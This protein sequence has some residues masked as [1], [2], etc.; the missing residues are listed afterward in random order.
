LS[1]EIKALIEQYE[2]SEAD[3][4]TAVTLQIMTSREYKGTVQDIV[5]G[6]VRHQVTAHTREHTRRVEDRAFAHGDPFME[7]VGEL[8]LANP[9]AARQELLREKF[10]CP[11]CTMY[12]TWGEATVDC[13][14]GR[15]KYMLAL[16]NTVLQDADR[17]QAA[18]DKLRQYGVK[19]LNEL[20]SKVLAVR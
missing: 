20:E 13:H 6:Y 17:H 15:R 1:A 7:V 11:H 19:T 9:M 5:L 12:V 14:E 16:A 18:L 2:G 3:I 8:P 4:A 10:F